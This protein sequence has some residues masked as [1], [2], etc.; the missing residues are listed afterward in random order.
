MENKLHQAKN[1]APPMR[2]SRCSKI[3]SATTKEQS[4]NTIYTTIIPPFSERWQLHPIPHDQS[5]PGIQQSFAIS[6]GGK[7][8]R[9]Q[10]CTPSVDLN[11]FASDAGGSSERTV[12]EDAAALPE[13]NDGSTTDT[14]R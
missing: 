12:S 8:A 9:D 7:Q 14:D 13:I 6:S 4:H 3:G 11:V 10:Y 1:Y 2:K 5:N